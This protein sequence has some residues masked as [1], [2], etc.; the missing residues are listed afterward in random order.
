MSIP[1]GWDELQV[2]DL[3]ND[4]LREIAKEYSLPVAVGIWKRFRGAGIQVPSRFTPEYCAGFV[5]RHWDG[6]NTAQIAR[7]LGVSQRTVFSLLGASSSRRRT[8]PD[9][10]SLI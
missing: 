9:Q 8:D 1:S 6:H 2:G 4:D 10:L 7:A 3:P 5:E